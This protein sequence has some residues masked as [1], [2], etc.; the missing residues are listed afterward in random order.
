VVKTGEHTPLALAIVE[1][2]NVLAHYAIIFQQNDNVPILER[3]ILHDKDQD[4][5][6]CQYVTEY[7]LAAIF[8]DLSDH[9]LEFTLLKPNMVTHDHSCT[10]KF[11]NKEIAMASVTAVCHH[12][13]PP[14]V[15]GVVFLFV[16]QNEERAF[17]NLNDIKRF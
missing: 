15:P 17:I 13:V 2:V 1:N 10:H 7:V 12:T 11:S 14:A 4:L 6:S 9:Y 16:G 3:E 8:K 5:E